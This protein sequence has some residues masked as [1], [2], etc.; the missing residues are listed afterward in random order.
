MSSPPEVPGGAGLGLTQ[1]FSE[2]IAESPKDL[3]KI[4]IPGPIQDLRNENLG[5]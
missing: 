4:Q 2:Y 5:G 1:G 3:L